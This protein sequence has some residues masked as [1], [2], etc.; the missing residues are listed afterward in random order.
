[1]CRVFAFLERIVK[2]LG[3]IIIIHFMVFFFFFFFRQIAKGEREGGGGQ[4][5]C[6]YV[7]VNVCTVI[8]K[9]ISPPTPL[10]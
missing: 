8:K 3:I 10:P 2:L 7:H 4:Y 1:M 6:Q 9:R 5:V